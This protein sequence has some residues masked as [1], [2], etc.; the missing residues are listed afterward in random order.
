MHNYN[1]FQNKPASFALYTILASSKKPWRVDVFE[2]APTLE[3]I[4]SRRPAT[5][6]H[7]LP[8]SPVTQITTLLW[9]FMLILD[10]KE[11][12]VVL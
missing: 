5:L 1:L 9:R 8:H 6:R 12:S 4:D 7:A 11:H 10:H 2:S 3:T